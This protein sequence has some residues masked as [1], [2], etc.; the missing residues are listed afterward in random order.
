[1]NRIPPDLARPQT[2]GRTRPPARRRPTGPGP[3]IVLGL[4][5]LVPALAL[6][7]LFSWSDGKVD[8]ADPVPPTPST[9]VAP[10]PPPDPLV[11][12]VLTFRRMP[13]VLSRELNI[14]RFRADAVPF[15]ASINER[16]CVSISVDGVPVG[17]QNGALPVI[18]ASNQKIVVAAVALE[19][20][21]A[22]FTYRTRVAA[23]DSPVDGVV[24]GDLVLFGGGDPLLTSNWYP[25]SNLERR[26]VFNQTSLDE[27][28]DRV[29][30]AG[31]TTITGSV[32]GDGSR[33]DDEFFAPGWGN[34]VA[35][36]E[37]GPYDALMANDA[38]VL[39]E[40]QRANDPNSG[41]AR[42]FTRLLSERG[43]TVA[44]EPASGSI[45]VLPD[46]FHEIASIDSQPLT[47]V[48]QEMLANSDN[49]TAELM[50]KEI[51]FAA[52]GG[53]SGTRQAGLD[54]MAATL[55]EWGVDTSALRLSDGSGLSLENLLTCDALIAVLQRYD[56][57]SAVGAGLPVAGETGTLSD[58]FVDHPL[59]GRL[60]GKTGTLN[61]PPFNEDP[62]AVKALAGYVPVD[63]GGAVEYALV[64]NGP[65]ISDQSEYRPVWNELADL[66]ATYPAGPTP[67]DLGPI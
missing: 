45:G 26:P 34:G 55:L 37:A 18:P 20:L 6:Y 15:L 33:Y 10:A 38:R 5:A 52:T 21:G 50:V 40:D 47:A 56:V 51:G 43:I 44:G 65:T 25:T 67:A 16:S 8:T 46:G 29:Q 30:Q 58:I 13:T 61:N 66:L 42:E 24:D 7:S 35:G 19:V 60:L 12:E 22:D 36:L 62:P 49:N 53:A 48:V 14:E 28:A 17:S 59:A 3:L 2:G 11:N 57:T 32:L 63:G 41:A 54:A 39:G 31:V 27:L 23:A 64:L 1:M 4:F 9:V